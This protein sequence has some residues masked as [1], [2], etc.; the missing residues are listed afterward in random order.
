MEAKADQRLT[1]D[2]CQLG[3]LLDR[4]SVALEARNVS[5]TH[6]V[7]DLF[8]ARLAMHIR[9]EHL[10][11][12]P[13][14]LRAASRRRSDGSDRELPPEQPESMIAR[15]RNDHNF[16][17]HELA[18]AITITRHLLA[19]E[20]NTAEQL[21]AVAEKVLA[22]RTRLIQHNDIEETGVYFWSG[23]L[24]SEAEQSELASQVQKELDNVP[25]R[26]GVV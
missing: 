1:H 22:V 9:A 19:N 15:L 13:A 26:F 7:L 8:W 10:H 2:H 23:K 5:Q 3:E 16:F 11:L 21:G 12:F 6:A 25:P 18:K 4:V 14:L 24:L 20:G 17:M